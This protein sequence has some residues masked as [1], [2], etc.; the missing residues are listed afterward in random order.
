VEEWFVPEHMKQLANQSTRF[1]GYDQQGI[2]DYDFDSHGFRTGTT[3]GTSVINL[4]GNSISFGIGLPYDLTFGCLVAK[5]LNKKLNNYS[6]GC[7]LHENH[8]N[9]SNIKKLVNQPNNDAYIIQINNLD[10]QRIDSS[11]VITNNDPEFSKK[12]FLNYFDQVIELLKNNPTIFL[13]WDDMQ[14]DLPKSVTDQILIFNKF[15]LDNSLPNNKNTFG[16]K[17][18]RVISEILKLKLA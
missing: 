3:D 13:Y 10:R 15:F 1:F 17:T 5:N 6:F 11:T 16:I 18:N 7:Y 12:R 8:D 2:I 14:Y 4:I 9:L